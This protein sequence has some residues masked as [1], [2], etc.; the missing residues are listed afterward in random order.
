MGE[1]EADLK[2]HEKRLQNAKVK[3]ESAE[4]KRYEVSLSYWDN[5][6]YFKDLLFRSWICYTDSGKEGTRAVST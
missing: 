5:L 1:W 4:D 6:G 2:V 3:M